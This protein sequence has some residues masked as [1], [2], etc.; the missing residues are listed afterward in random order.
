MNIS[1]LSFL[2]TPNLEEGSPASTPWK[3]AM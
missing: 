3:L 2:P 1:A